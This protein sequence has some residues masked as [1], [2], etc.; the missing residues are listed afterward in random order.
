MLPFAF[1][2]AC[3]S[4]A[5]TSDGFLFLDS[6]GGYKGGILG[7]LL[8]AWNI[9]NREFHPSQLVSTVLEF[10]G[11]DGDKEKYI[12][13]AALFAFPLIKAVAFPI[14]TLKDSGQCALM[15]VLLERERFPPLQQL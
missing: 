11:K 3:Y 8:F 4:A 10:D 6:L 12:A 5:L 1:C 15:E 9:L 7:P 2:P 13:I 14:E